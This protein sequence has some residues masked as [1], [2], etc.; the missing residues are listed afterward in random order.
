[1]RFTEAKGHKVVDASRAETVGRV[2]SLLVDPRSRSVVALRLKKTDHGDLL[3][4]SRLSAFGHDA[5]TIADTSALVEKDEEL[6]PFGGK[7]RR[8]LKKRVLSTRGDEL[9]T[10]RDVEFDAETGRLT[11]I[12]LREGEDVSADRLV[13]VGSYAVVVRTEPGEG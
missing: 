10:V 12:L 13:G 9:G 8:L 7:R 2:R 5:V 1:M 6:E 11:T 4:W 3:R